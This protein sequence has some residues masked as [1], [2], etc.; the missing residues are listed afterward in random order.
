MNEVFFILLGVLAGIVVSFF[1]QRKQGAPNQ[2]LLSQLSVI[3]ERLGEQKQINTQQAEDIRDIRKELL[4]GT[5]LQ[6]NLKDGIEKT[7]GIL[8][9][10]KT[11]EQVRR[12]KE[13]EFIERIKRVDQIIAGTSA[14][15]MTGEKILRET[16][17]KLPPEMIET[18]FNVKGKTVEFALIL[19][20]NKRLP[21]DSKWPAGKLLLKLEKEKD[22]EKRNE[23]VSEIEKETIKRIK[24]VKQYIDPNVTWSQA[25]AAVPDSVYSVC[26]EAPL[27]AR[28]E[29]VILMPYSM[30]LPLLLYMYRLHLQYSVSIDLENLQNHLKNITRNL[31]EMEDV[32]ENK[33]ARG[34]TMISNAYTEYRQMIN[35]IKGSVNELQ[36]I[37]TK[38]EDNQ[39]E[40]PKEK[41]E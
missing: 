34:N 7:K 28:E 41:K 11:A 10:L 19:P 3:S 31:G 17:K 13:E 4:I 37:E 27:K 1:I 40:E 16:F 12:E 20:N 22:P 30:V 25:I 32:L 6:G 33:I 15:G 39:L 9:E 18:N 35:R 29:D 23:I 2:E 14:K 21:I 38:K 5:Q 8:E 24:E 36:I 26:R